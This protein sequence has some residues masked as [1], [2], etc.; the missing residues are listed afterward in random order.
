MLR[1]YLV[2]GRPTLLAQPPKRRGRTRTDQQTRATIA[3]NATTCYL[4]G[5][6]PR[7]NDPFTIDHIT[8]RS[9]G[10]PDHQTN[11]A[12]AHRTCNSRKGTR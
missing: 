3:A 11:Y 7:T 2:N 12:V 10:G 5:Q 8:P 1:T 9:Q 4:C 6:G